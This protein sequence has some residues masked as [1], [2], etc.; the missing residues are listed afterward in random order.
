MVGGLDDGFYCV[1]GLGGRTEDEL[2]DLELAHGVRWGGL[3]V[4][5]H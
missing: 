5:L 4:G 1:D 2:L 3:V